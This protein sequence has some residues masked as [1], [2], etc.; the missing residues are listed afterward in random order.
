MY[1]NQFFAD[2]S[3]VKV[4]ELNAVYSTNINM[5]IPVISSYV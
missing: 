1:Q 3:K 5:H 2:I 4:L